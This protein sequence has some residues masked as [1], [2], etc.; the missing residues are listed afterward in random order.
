MPLFSGYKTQGNP[1]VQRSALDRSEAAAQSVTDAAQQ[2]GWT[3]TAYR[4]MQSNRNMNLM[5]RAGSRLQKQ[6]MTSSSEEEPISNRFP[7]A[8][9]ASGSF[10]PAG[11]ENVTADLKGIM[12]EFNVEEINLI[13]KEDLDNNQV[14]KQLGLKFETATTD[15]EVA[16]VV[17]L[18]RN[19]IRNNWILQ[20]AHGGRF[21]KGMA[22]SMGMA[23]L[24]PMNVAAIVVP[25]PLAV[26]KLGIVSKYAYLGGTTTA[27]L[28]APIYLQAQKEQAD[29]TAEMSFI[30]IAFG[31]II[32][33]AFGG[34]GKGFNHYQATKNHAIK[35]AQDQESNMHDA[36]SQ[37]DDLHSAAGNKINDDLKTTDELAE[38]IIKLQ[39]K[40]RKLKSVD[41][42]DVE[43]RKNLTYGELSPDEI[44]GHIKVLENKKK[45]EPIT[46][47]E[48]QT[49]DNLK[50]A[51]K[52]DKPDSFEL[53]ELREQIKAKKKLYNAKRE[54][55]P[56]VILAKKNKKLQKEIKDKY[57]K[58]ISEIE[59]LAKK[60]GKKLTGADI[61]KIRKYKKDAQKEVAI[62]EEQIDGYKKRAAE[63]KNKSGVQF[64]EESIARSKKRR[65]RASTSDIEPEAR[66]RKPD[67]TTKKDAD[68]DAEFVAIGEK[69]IKATDSDP[70]LKAES[71]EQIN[72]MKKTILSKKDF[73]ELAK[74]FEDI[75][76]CTKK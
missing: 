63:Q 61:A 35:I 6:G 11:R 8:S 41:V 39:K 7:S 70:T 27:L 59:R 32:G 20:R 15:L 36:G 74:I 23:M 2:M 19:E 17:K 3:Y 13:S 57:A 76:N 44:R 64:V 56:E 33:G 21:F 12:S 45:K 65:R 42:S 69:Y 10:L 29:Y 24:D 1:F 46:K 28:E 73:D 9:N 16:Y 26:A 58:L 49:L 53:N 55:K 34:I 66:Y 22:I 38:E 51:E 48:Q 25:V 71:L 75:V 31:T 40:S 14:L 67:E 5:R 47:K 68:Y 72:L 4:S 54:S 30:N 52:Q 50:K 43:F 37:S 62:L 60:K 18:K